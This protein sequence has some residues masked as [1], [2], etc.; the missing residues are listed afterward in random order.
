MLTNYFKIAFRNLTKYKIFTSI[1]IVG[2]SV[3]I[4]VSMLL[5][6]TAFKELSFDNFH[7]NGDQIYRVYFE[8]NRAAGVEKSPTVPF[9]ARQAFIEDYP[10]IEKSTRVMNGGASIR[11]K[12]K[13]NTSSIRYVDA[14]FLQ[15]FNFPL[16]EG[17]A[18]QALNDLSSVVITQR[19]AS[20]LFGTTSPIGKSISFNFGNVKKDY[21]VSGVMKP[22]PINSTIRFDV[23]LRIENELSYQTY[24]NEWD[25]FNH[26]LFVQLP[27]TIT[28][29]QF[30]KTA[31]GFCQKYFPEKITQLKTDG[32]KQNSDGEIYQVRL[33]SLGDL[34]FGK[35]LETD[36]TSKNFK[37]LL[38]IALLIMGGFILAIACMNFV[39]LTLGNSI[40]RSVEVGVRKVLGANR[41]QIINQFWMEAILVIASA[42]LLGLLLVQWALPHYMALFNISIQLKSAFVILPIGLILIIVVLLG[43]VYPGLVISR[44]NASQIFKRET[45][46]QKPGAIRNLLVVAQFAISILLICCTIIV[47]QQLDYLRT[48][49][50]GYNKN[51]VISIPVG[52]ELSGEKALALM[53]NKLANDPQVI[54][55]TGSYLNLGLGK[56]GSSSTSIQT[57]THQGRELRMH[58]YRVDYDY[59]K[60]IDVELI[61]GREFSP[62]YKSDTSKA[63]IIN[64][65]LAKSIGGDEVLGSNL[66]EID[67]V[68]VGIFKDFN[69]KSLNEPIEPLAFEMGNFLPL[70]YIFVK[71]APNNLNGSMQKLSSIWKEI[72]PRSN[73]EASF[74]DENTQRQYSDEDRL[75]KLFVMASVLAILLSCLGLFA[76]AVLIIVQRTKE[77]GVRK[78]LGASVGNIVALLSVDFLKL[79]LIATLIATPFAWYTMSQWLQDFAYHIDIQWWVFFLAGFLALVI[80]FLTI[81]WQSVRA[82]LTNPVESLKSE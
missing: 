43:G 30:E 65:A 74:L 46:L 55:I 48:K 21:L 81:S 59:L 41:L 72:A 54:S 62:N 7:Q 32:A 45:K 16:V 38:P 34:H 23:L 11:Y 37:W 26:N 71:V 52:N 69:F 68:V 67:K 2:L 15:M 12:E 27:T 18:Q 31:K 76:V 58:W 4:A 49:S 82:A 75:S 60:T 66:E 80:A 53:R 8:M 40:N 64:E 24:K 33:Q 17:D 50:L 44:F 3:A 42:L 36:G 79:V 1:N 78:I 25:N 9:P 14:D 10:G 57:I 61:T 51:Q 13:T 19:V 77:I 35:E 70:N 63:V 56:D 22:T 39:N 73:F 6:L 28:K 29:N 47:A 20:A 5:F